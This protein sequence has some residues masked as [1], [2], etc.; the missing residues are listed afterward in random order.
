MTTDQDWA[1][2]YR[3]QAEVCREYAAKATTQP[4][5]GAVAE[6]RRRLERACGSGGA[7]TSIDQARPGRSPDDAVRC[8]TEQGLP[9]CF[10]LAAP[11]RD[12]NAGT[13]G[14]ARDQSLSWLAETV[15]Q[16]LALIQETD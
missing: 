14:A 2:H 8:R 7:L 1:A 13:R 4:L 5:R 15:S 3:A 6:V 16:L 10:P 11:L 9:G 12:G